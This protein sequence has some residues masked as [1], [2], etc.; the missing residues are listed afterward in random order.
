MYRNAGYNINNNY[1]KIFYS[2]NISLNPNIIFG[3][4]KVIIYL[5]MYNNIIVWLF[6]IGKA[7]NSNFE[8][9]LSISGL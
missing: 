3:S 6:Q 5:G 8:T 4:S 7:F 1:F 2:Y 9:K